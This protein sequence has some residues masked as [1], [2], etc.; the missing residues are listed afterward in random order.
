MWRWPIF[1]PP[2]HLVSRRLQ[3]GISDLF[4]F[5][6]SN[7]SLFSYPHP[8]HSA[9]SASCFLCSVCVRTWSNI[10]DLTFRNCSPSWSHASLYCPK[11]APSK[12]VS[13]I[14]AEIYKKHHKISLKNAPPDPKGGVTAFFLKAFFLGGASLWNWDAPHPQHIS[15]HFFRLIVGGKHEN[16]NK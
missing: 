1:K 11:I 8:V 4:F 5:A 16:M 9:I 14:A 6:A 7:M 10:L 12:H 13:R 15:L 3:G 2:P